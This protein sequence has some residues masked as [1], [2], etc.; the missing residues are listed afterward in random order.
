VIFMD[1]KGKGRIVAG[2]SD[3]TLFCLS[4]EGNLLWS[5]PL[6]SSL[7][8]SVSVGDLDEEGVADLF[9]VTSAGR[10]YRLTEE[11]EVVWSL[12]MHMR[13]DAPGAIADLDGD[14]SLDY[15]LCTHKGTLLGLN[16]SGEIILKDSLGV[17]IAYNATPSLS[18]LAED[19]V[20]LETVVSGGDSGYVF[21]FATSAPNIQSVQWNGVR[22]DATM[23]GFWT[24]LSK[25]ENAKMFPM[26]LSWDHVFC[27]EGF[28][29]RVLDHRPEGPALTAQASCVTPSGHRYTVVREVKEQEMLFRLKAP[30]LEPGAYAVSWSLETPNSPPI[31]S[32]ERNLTI[33]PF[34][35]DRAYVEGVFSRLGKT[36]QELHLSAPL[37]SWALVEKRDLLQ[38]RFE[39]LIPAQEEALHGNAAAKEYALKETKSLLTRARRLDEIGRFL[40]GEKGDANTFGFWVREGI[41]WESR[42]ADRPVLEETPFPIVR[43]L[44]PGEHE[45]LLL[46]LFNG[47]DR[48]LQLLLRSRTP[49]GIR[50]SILRP[51]VVPTSQGREAWDALPPLDE[52]NIFSIPSLAA[53]QIWV[54]LALED[55]LPSG[56]HRVD[57]Q[58]QAINGPGVLEGPGSVR[59]IPPPER[60]VNIQLEVFSLPMAHPSSFRL[61]TWEAVER[62]FLR[63]TPKEAYKDLLEHG[64]NVFMVPPPEAVYDERGRIEGPIQYERLDEKLALFEGWDVFLLFHSRPALRPKEGGRGY[65]TE[66]YKRALPPYMKSLQ[67]HLKEKGY[68]TDRF[69]LYPIDEPGGRDGWVGINEMVAFG[70][71]AKEAAPEVWVYTNAYGPTGLPMLEALAPYIDVW[72]PPVNMVACEENKM[73]FLRQMGIPLWS[74]NCSY[75]NYNKLMTASRTLKEADIVSEYRTAGIWAFRHGL[76]G[77][78]FWTYCCSDDDPW[79][80]TETEYVLVYPGTTGPVTSRRWE[81]V[82]EGIEDFRILTALRAAKEDKGDGLLSEESRSAIDRLLRESIP[83]FVDGLT[84]E[85]GLRS[86]RREIMDCVARVCEEKL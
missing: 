21:C 40:Q 79:T 15:F 20:G 45:P 55:E 72:A 11:G 66:A 81:A 50:A 26:D 18:E 5:L 59:A 43:R 60:V 41:V 9:A 76:Q 28:S 37:S 38:A 29:F 64:N 57:L 39:A 3:G 49:A 34:F 31:V 8:S 62:S 54:D 85:E 16:D 22:K 33:Q 78:G 82:R 71:M 80:R 51:S 52:S 46:S 84:K 70:K 68:D 6:G 17:P 24:G 4:A 7:D 48:D 74:Y 86:L 32:E 56:T 10:V 44:V 63:D 14:G 30:L 2:S 75:N 1:S 65:G 61:C 25:T 67:R 35:N 42:D 58:F 23:T 27:D 47:T 73:A 69:A 36:I 53:R 83:N 13:T 19:R 77:T 12:D